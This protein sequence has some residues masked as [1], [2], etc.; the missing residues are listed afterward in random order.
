MRRCAQATRQPK[1]NPAVLK[2]ER[3]VMYTNNPKGLQ[4][5]SGD[6]VM[7]KGVRV[8]SDLRGLMFETTGQ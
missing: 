3:Q 6:P 8:E 4:T 2:P 7:L 1:V 5:M